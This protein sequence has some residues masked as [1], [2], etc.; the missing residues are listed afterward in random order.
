MQRHLKSETHAYITVKSLV[1]VASL[2]SLEKGCTKP[3]QP[4]KKGYLESRETVV[5]TEYAIR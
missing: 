5:S 4:L 1:E 3:S 2:C